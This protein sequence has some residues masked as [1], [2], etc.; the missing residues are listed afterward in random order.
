MPF[1]AVF[2][3]H[4]SGFF[5]SHISRTGSAR[6]SA[7]ENARPVGWRRRFPMTSASIKIGSSL[8]LRPEYRLLDPRESAFTFELS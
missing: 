8:A 6:A 2:R 7:F 3:A 5:A 1:P 4:F